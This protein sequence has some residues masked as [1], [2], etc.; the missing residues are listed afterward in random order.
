MRYNAQQYAEI[1]YE[2]TD[3]TTSIKRREVIREFLETVAKNG[4]LPLLTEIQREFAHLLDVKKG[5]HVVTVK[6]SERL[7][8]A[9]VA[10]K[11]P[12]KSRVNAIRDVRLSGGIAL[13]TD[14]LRVDNSVAGRLTRARE[15]LVR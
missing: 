11:L 5:V 4:A 12:F 13:E 14:G 2:L 8:P 10:R 7:E 3:V 9:S 15:A 1:L 6:S